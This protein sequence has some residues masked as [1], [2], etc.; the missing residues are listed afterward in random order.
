MNARPPHDAPAASPRA[1]AAVSV[2]ILTRDEALNLPFA[3]ASAKGWSDDVHVVDSGSTDGTLDIA[4]SAGA[5][6]HSHPWTGWGDQRNWALGNCGL[7]YDWVLFLDADEQL[8]QASRKETAERTAAAPPECGGYYLQFDYV[9]LGKR[10]RRAMVP[11]LR[12]VRRQAAHWQTV[13]AR[14]FCN[15]PADSPRIHARLVHEDHRGLGYFIDKLN[16]NASLEA[17][18]L[19]ASRQA[20]RHQDEG[21]RTSGPRRR[22]IWHALQL[23]LPPSLRALAFFAFCLLCRMDLRDGRTGV[24][25]CFYFGFW[26]HLLLE[27]KY[28]ELCRKATAENQ[29]EA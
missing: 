7:K 18:A 25:F 24:L 3:L 28:Q 2:V 20:A 21:N 16:R 9:F 8:T 6:V 13:G 19:W 1:G 10:L 11:H 22:R 29:P 17:D 26:Y 4:R 5:S 23:V 27:S 12:L 14:E 15:L